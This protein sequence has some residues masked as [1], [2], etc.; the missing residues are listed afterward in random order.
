MPVFIGWIVSALVGGILGATPA[1]VKP[2]A[3]SNFER[4]VVAHLGPG[5]DLLEG[6]QKVA[7]AERIHNG[8]IL[9]GIGSVTDYHFHVVSDKNLP[10]AETY[11][12][13]S[14]AKDLTSLQGYILGGR[15][16]AHMTLSDENSVVGGHVEPGTKALTFF[17]V[18]IGVLPS[19]LELETLDR[20]QR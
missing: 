11:P 16:H 19:E 9:A 18:T 7:S 15:I 3:V 10:P 8:V 20:L 14:V 5:T 13:A 17:I 4:I 12:Q 6:L 2:A 1:P